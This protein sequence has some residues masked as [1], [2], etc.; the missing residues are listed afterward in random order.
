MIRGNIAL[1]RTERFETPHEISKKKLTE[2]A[3]KALDKLEQNLPRW[4][5]HFATDYSVH[6][7]Y[8]QGV[9][10]HWECG[11]HTGLYWLAYEMSG[12]KKFRDAAEKHMPTYRERFDKKICLNDHDVGF[13]YTPACVAAY[14][15][16]GE[17][18][19]RKLALEAADYYY[20]AGYSQ[21]GGFILRDWDCE[22]M[23]GACRTMMDTL[24][25]APFLFWAGMESSKQEYIDAALS[26]NKITEKYLIR[27]D[28]SSYH[29]YQFDVK[30]HQPLYGL[31]WQG[32]SDESCWSRGHAWGIYG[33]PTAYGYCKEEFLINLHRDITYYML[34][35]L[36]EDY[37]PHW[38][39]I[40]AGSKE[41]P[42]DSSA[43]VIS[44]CGMKEMCKF[45]SEDA[46]QKKIFENAAARMLEAV[47]DH[48]TEDIEQKYDG[49]IYHVTHALPQGLGIDECAL[50]GDYFYL[51]ALMRFINPDW[52]GYW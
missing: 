1:E 51:E 6:F 21:K 7:K 44:V 11:M 23:V 31:T 15:V 37:I 30:T 13:V 20:H 46:P 43:G 40:Y 45:L 16:T 42:R 19:Y 36:P 32:A 2:A 26:Q 22:D 3:Q 48:C 49:L 41:Q 35:K 34:N 39:Y 28:G 29:H 14:K 25:N 9:N 5:N 17:E 33:F 10:N 47:I 52:K 38:D 18:K 27:E 4:E 24:M 50:Y 8:P 12:N